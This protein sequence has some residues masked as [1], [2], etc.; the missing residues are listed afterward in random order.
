MGMYSAA[1]PVTMAMITSNIGG[2]T[3]RSTVNA[4]YFVMYCAGNVIGPQLFFES[5]APRY[6]VCTTP[7]VYFAAEVLWE[8]LIIWWVR[9]VYNRFWFVWRLWWLIVLD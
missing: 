4:I 6:Q 1:M 8:K 9:V 5:E 2:F 7:Y 3:K